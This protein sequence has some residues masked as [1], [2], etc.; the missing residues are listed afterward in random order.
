ML[1][2]GLNIDTKLTEIPF[3]SGTRY[4]PIR[5]RVGGMGV[6]IFCEDQ[7]TGE[8]VAL[9]TFKPEILHDRVNRLRFMQ[10]VCDWIHLGSHPNLVQ[11]YRVEQFGYPDQPYLVL[12]AI[13]GRK[14]G[15][16]VSL[17]HILH[18][19][20]HKQLPIQAS[21]TIALHVARAMQHANQCMDNYVH[22]DI[23]PANILLDPT[24]IARLTDFGI[25]QSFA[26]V[27][28]NQE[29]PTSINDESPG[30]FK[31]AGSV[32]YIAPEQWSPGTT[33][34]TGVDIYA[35]GLTLYELLT[36]LRRAQGD[37]YAMVREA[38]IN[39]KLLAIPATMPPSLSTLIEKCTAYNP[40]D[41]FS[42]WNLVEQAICMCFEELL[43][44]PAP[45]L[46]IAVQI[47]ASA[48]EHAQSNYAVAAS[49]QNLGFM[50]TALAYSIAAVKQAGD[51]NDA[52]L[53][54]KSLH[55]SALINENLGNREQAIET[56]NKALLTAEQLCEL[57]L[58]LD[59]LMLLGS[60]YARASNQA[61]AQTHLQHAL[62][63]A[64]DLGNP[65][66]LALVCGNVANAFAE[67]GN[68]HEAIKIYREQLAT[69]EQNGDPLNAN[70]CL[71]NM[72]VAQI[73]VGE[74]EDAIAGLTKSL[75]T[76]E[77]YADAFGKTYALKHL[78]FAS[79]AN[80]D[81][82]QARVWLLRFKAHVVN[83]QDAKEATWAVEQLNKM[84]KN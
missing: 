76:A 77:E 17:A 63:I 8:S 22:R 48:Q 1:S 58:Q 16:D 73:E 45:P 35:L 66:T 34:N 71:G 14:P 55:Q 46:P 61:K 11:A 7:L 84:N 25:A 52:L 56:L 83:W 32:S 62:A 68:F 4:T 74:L 40:A 80:N 49:Y 51:L 67:T 36:G 41:R 38:H 69:L 82:Q 78:Y 50:D 15:D 44:K 5:A 54:I 21:L 23:K 9:K 13:P 20:P 70:K 53:L 24:G 79:M 26:D 31:P 3:P 75:N 37:S 59:C 28:C 60:L 18:S 33:A 72:A 19:L 29:L 42:N 39:G 2:S 81:V 64:N 6:V 12:E 43:N 10:E 27:E 30:Q 47:Q 57:E 65:E